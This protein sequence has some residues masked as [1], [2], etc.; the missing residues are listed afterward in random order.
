MRLGLLLSGLLMLAGGPA[1]SQDS[2]G[3]PNFA[4]D[5][6]PVLK[7]FCAQCHSGERPR[8]G[9]SLAFKDEKEA[10]A[11]FKTWERV[12]EAL[13]KREMPP[14]GKP[15]PS[16]SQL[17]R[18][19]RWMDLVVFKVDCNGPRDP[20]R[21]TM[22]RLNRTEYN[23]T[24]RDLVGVDFKPAK[25]FPEDDSGYGFDNIGDVLS[26]PP[27][28][29]EKYLAAAETIVDRA[30]ENPA[31]KKKLLGSTGDPNRFIGR[32]EGRRIL[33]RFAERAYRRPVSR[34]EV[35]RLLRFVELARNNGDSS[36]TGLR[37]AFQ[38]ILVSPH[39]LFRVEGDPRPGSVRTL[40]DYELASRLSYFLWSTMPDE[41]LLESAARE[42]LHRP[43]VLE[44]QV[45]RML[46]DPR[47]RALSGN[48]AMQW[49][50]IR[51]LNEFAPD[52]KLFPTFT[53]ALRK[54]MLEETRL[55]FDHVVREDRSILEFIDADYTFL[56]ERLAKH[57]GIPGVG[58]EKFQK[59]EYPD[60][61]RG[62][63]L[64]H[65]S[66]LSVTSN[67]TRTSPVKRG[68]WIMENL[69]GTPPP[70]PP[71][72]VPE[73][74]DE[75]GGPL[76]GTL[77]QRMEQHRVNP[78]CA[79]C[80][81]QMDALGF[82]FENFDAIG[83]WRTHDGRHAIDPSGELPG[84]IGFRGPAELRIILKDRKED[85]A[86]CLTEKLL[87]YA[88]GRGLE[89]TD[90]CFVDDIVARLAKDNFK[91]SRLVLEIAKSEPFQ[92]RRGKGGNP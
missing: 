34:D 52:P 44:K 33:T 27:L 36:E 60:K 47:A 84:K 73:L 69:L 89:R 32:T 1:W 72:D 70:P 61:R 30:W 49:L 79:V 19:N 58:G 67:P 15:A 29:L 40:N 66:V 11:Q 75:K 42:E 68:K 26:L 38:A 90:K 63:I 57:Y 62:G 25:D 92:K 12:A 80:H 88:L 5:V 21:V 85:F 35:D 78:N 14:Q 50:T 41:E 81:N 24:I 43:D 18:V 71:P 37:L 46:R 17:D 6:A 8:S 10:L 7:E 48:F 31:S 59:I 45:Q 54:D 56:N 16:T 4:R 20:G 22:R 64:T 28:L 74:E 82:A 53:D 91:F 77:R 87:T 76:E 51:S 65:A 9:L 86:R 39:F 3:S 2:A 55:F 13:R 83:S 23:N